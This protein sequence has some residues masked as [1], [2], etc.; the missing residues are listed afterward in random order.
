MVRGCKRADLEADI[1][2][3][4]RTRHVRPVKKRKNIPDVD[5]LRR[6]NLGQ[7]KQTQYTGG[8]LW[9]GRFLDRFPHR[10]PFGGPP[11]L[12]PAQAFT[13]HN[14]MAN[15]SSE[16]IGGIHLCALFPSHARFW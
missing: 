9:R 4:R 16:R 14:F 2:D 15:F 7:I 3:E 5:L 11:F 13:F 1:L 10:I 6:S 8:A 12:E